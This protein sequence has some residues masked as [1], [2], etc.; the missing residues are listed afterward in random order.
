MCVRYSLACV[1]KW[2]YKSGGLSGGLSGGTKYKNVIALS[3]ETVHKLEDSVNADLFVID[4]VSGD[5][6]H[7]MEYIIGGYKL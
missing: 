2:W 5:F 4:T 3:W 6:L 7:L 1:S